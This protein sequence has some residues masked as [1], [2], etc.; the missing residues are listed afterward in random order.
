SSRS[1]GPTSWS[2]G[3]G[4]K[5]HAFWTSSN[6]NPTG[7]A[8]NPALM[9]GTIAMDK[10]FPKRSA[11]RKSVEGQGKYTVNQNPAPPDPKGKV[12]GVVETAPTMWAA[13]G[14]GGPADNSKQ[15]TIANGVWNGG[16]TNPLKL[17]NLDPGKPYTIFVPYDVKI[18]WQLNGVQQKDVRSSAIT[19]E[20]AL[21]TGVNHGFV[22][23]F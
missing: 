4:A 11:D 1:P 12:T 5:H 6:V 17:V 18:Q 21:K 2:D 16:G 8:I 20:I 22:R 23:G 9:G 19:P 10:G 15:S 7:L 3:S 13:I 14:P